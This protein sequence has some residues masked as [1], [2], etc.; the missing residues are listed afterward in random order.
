MLKTSKF[1]MRLICFFIIQII[2][3]NVV[4][5]SP[6]KSDQG[7]DDKL[8]NLIVFHE[9]KD[10]GYVNN[11][12]V[13]L[14]ALKNGFKFDS[15]R[16]YVSYGVIA[17]TFGLHTAWLSDTHLKLI[18]P[19]NEIDIYFNKSNLD[20]NT[21]YYNKKLSKPGVTFLESDSTYYLPLDIFSELLGKK[22]DIVDGLIIIS[23]KQDSL[24]VKNDKEL[25]KELENYFLE[26]SYYERKMI[27]KSQAHFDMS[28]NDLDAPEDNVVYISTK[29]NGKPY[30]LG[31]G[32]AI[33]DGLYITDF[34]TIKFADTISVI[35]KDRRSYPAEGIVKFDENKNLAIIKT[36]SLQ[37]IKP[38][39]IATMNEKTEELYVITIKDISDFEKISDDKVV[40]ISRDPLG[41]VFSSITSAKRYYRYKTSLFTLSSSVFN[42]GS[43]VIDGHNLD[44]VFS[45]DDIKD[46]IYDLGKTPFSEIKTIDIKDQ[47]KS[48]LAEA[49]SKAVD[50]INKS[51]TALNDMDS[52]LYNSLL[53]S[54]HMEYVY[55]S[56][57]TNPIYNGG[58]FKYEVEEINIINN[59]N[60]EI[61]AEVIYI[62]T[63]F[64]DSSFKDFRS[65]GVF[66]IKNNHNTFRIVSAKESFLHFTADLNSSNT[67]DTGKMKYQIAKSFSKTMTRQIYYISRVSE[68]SSYSNYNS[69]T[70]DNSSIQLD[71]DF[72]KTNLK[73]PT[74]R[75][76]S[77]VGA[78]E[79]DNEEY[80]INGNGDF[81]AVVHPDTKEVYYVG[82]LKDIDGGI[83]SSIAFS[84]TSGKAYISVN[85][86]S[87]D[88][89]TPLVFGDIDHIIDLNKVIQ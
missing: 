59:Y 20:E 77:G 44:L 47:I 30:S 63:S 75:K 35:S 40:S 38:F 49:D 19:A 43:K 33:G 26:F 17:F 54:E 56:R 31:T 68:A 81:R 9:E 64:E 48:E 46:W 42:I 41:G 3:L 86:N 7:I 2:L 13:S 6:V 37:K 71:L 79:I 58:K 22:I 45:L 50:I 89:P 66:T 16:I 29:K 21:I 85:I 52:V 5:A 10:F 72:D 55:S 39:H 60:D 4:L 62:T 32:F 74:A 88:Y 1:K 82:S 34:N 25:L 18:A 69:L 14:K 51:F 12:K 76:V 61:T 53:D 57:F 11:N 67:L 78:I 24:D 15:N 65:K 27:K 70:Q 36:T 84:P 73:S 8:T 87:V 28:V 80:A 23:D 83:T